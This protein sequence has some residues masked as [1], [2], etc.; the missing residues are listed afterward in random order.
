MIIAH[1]ML[2][3]NTR[4]Q[5]GINNK[6]LASSTEKLSSGYRINRA[7]DDAA[8][9]SIS[10][11]MRAQVRGLN[12]GSRNSKDGISL[13]QTAD[14]ALQEVGDMLGRLKELAVQ[15]ANDTNTDADRLNIQDEV[16]GILEEID[17]IGN[18]TEFNTIKIFQGGE[19]EVGIFDEDGNRVSLDQIPF[20]DINFRNVSL[21]DGPFTSGSSANRL[22]LKASLSD[23][24]HTENSAISTSWNLIYGDGSTSSSN[25]RGSYV[26]DEGN[27]VKFNS[28]LD[29]MRVSNFQYDNVDTF[30]RVLSYSPAEDV[31]FEIQQDVKIVS[32]EDADYKYYDISYTVRNTGTREA[33]VDFLF[34][35]DTAYN[36]NDICEGY[37]INGNRVQT[38]RLYTRDPEYLGARQDVYDIGSVDFSNGLSIVDVDAALPFSESLR[39]DTGANGPDTVSIGHYYSIKD[40]SYYNNLSTN[41]EIGATAIR[42]DLGIGLLWS[43]TTLGANDEKTFSFSYGIANVENDPNLN[44]VTI[45]KSNKST[46]HSDELDLWIQSGANSWDG[47]YVTVGSMNTDILGLTNLSVTTYQNADNA[48]ARIDKATERISLQRS[49][50]GAYQNRLEYSYKSTDITAENVQASESRIRD[51]DMAD[52]MVE[53]SKSSI[54][55][56]ASQSMLAQANQI[57]QGVLQLLQ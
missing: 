51:I 5:V 45:S 54:L 36:N 6:A 26:D 11:G 33:N 48:N 23:K 40:W 7:A 20:S 3:D 50:L 46:V 52:G 10:E 12:R 56:Q 31:S 24:Y 38:N 9:L 16:Y 32:P 34:H 44:N 49:Q 4:R 15:A 27:T 41:N 37:F 53:N 2:A 47:M 29:D 35:A 1:N 18:D 13:I 8:G 25:F 28:T 39:W 43:D 21:Q 30:S 22:A 14:G 42:E 19:V 57:T 17:R 55:L